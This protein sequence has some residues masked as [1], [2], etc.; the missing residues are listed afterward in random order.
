MTEII[1]E[2]E[3]ADFLFQPYIECGEYRVRLIPKGGIIYVKDFYD[4]YNCLMYAM[5]VLYQSSASFS[6]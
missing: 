2:P 4:R 3:Q 1:L 5:Y 6:F